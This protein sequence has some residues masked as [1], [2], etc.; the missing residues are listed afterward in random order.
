MAIVRGSLIFIWIFFV[1]FPAVAQSTPVRAPA[2]STAQAGYG[3][4]VDQALAEYEADNFL[5]ARAQFRRAHQMDPNARTLRALGMVEFELRNY[6]DSIRWLELALK[7]GVRALEGSMRADT[8][9]LLGRAK[10]YVARVVLD[11]VPAQATVFVD[12]VETT[13]GAEPLSLVLGDHVLEFRA[14][15]RVTEKR[16]LKVEGGEA[17]RLRVVLS[18]LPKREAQRPVYKNAWLW[19]AVGAVVASAAAGTFLALNGREKTPE[20]PYGGTTGAV[21]TAPPK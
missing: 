15:G 16:R 5:E 19:T 3:E 11:V 12:G 14:P 10:T 1:V 6:R 21:L 9:A 17:T 13:L 2:D 8:E 20:E 18:E 7:S 4:A